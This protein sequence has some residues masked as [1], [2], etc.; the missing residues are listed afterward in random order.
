[1][2]RKAKDRSV[3]VMRF[4]SCGSRTGWDDARSYSA[5][6]AGTALARIKK[7]TGS[8]MGKHWSHWVATSRGK[9]LLIIQERS[10]LWKTHDKE[11]E[12]ELWTAE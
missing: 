1:M 3:T 5:T 10:F 7:G 4:E 12:E 8:C 6:T 2:N 9:G 11:R